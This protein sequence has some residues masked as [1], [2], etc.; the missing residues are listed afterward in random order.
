MA[1]K[2]KIIVSDLHLGAGYADAGNALEDFASDGEFVGLL[3]QVC[4]ESQATGQ[5]VEL[6]VNG[7]AFEMLQ[8]PNLE[9]F[10]PLFPYPPVVY[11]SSSEPDSVRKMQLI[12]TGHPRFFEALRHFLRL[13]PPRRSVTFVK[14]NHDINLHWRG[15]QAII[16][17]ALAAHGDRAKLVRFAERSVSRDGIYVEHGNQYAAVVDRVADFEEP[18]HPRHPDQL[19]LPA[20]SHFVIHAFNQVERTRYWIDGVKPVTALIWYALAFDT[21]WAV[22]AI[23]IL[24]AALPDVVHDLLAVTPEPEAEAPAALWRDLD[25]PAVVERY[26]SDALFRAAFQARLAQAL[27]DPMLPTEPES[28]VV[29]SDASPREAALRDPV[30]TA[31]AIQTQVNSA[32]FKAAAL[33]ARQEGA[34]VVVFGHTHEPVT[35]PLPDGGTYLNSGTWTWSSDLSHANREIWR[36]LFEHP[37]RFTGHRQLTYVR[38]EYDAAGHP[39]ARRLTYEAEDMPQPSGAADGTP[40][41]WQRVRRWLADVWEALVRFNM[42]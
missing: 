42:Q 16:R 1:G 41:W 30:S 33:K 2:F 12:V 20:G 27:G 28:M 26:T 35:E 23:R 17:R 14:G 37:E 34:D 36:E 32:L 40:L 13:D 9:E 4:T 5:S 7:D 31:R 10:D 18:H 15:T 22:Q 11:V 19:Q 25:D 21:A 38:V 39:A 6:I 29:S 3:A 8:T 24:L